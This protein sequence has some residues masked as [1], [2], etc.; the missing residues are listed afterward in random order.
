VRAIVNGRETLDSAR[1]VVSTDVDEP[2]APEITNA[3]CYDTGSIFV[4]WR[5]PQ[6]FFKSIDYYKLYYRPRVSGGDSD[7][8]RNVT[9]QASDSELQRVRPSHYSQLSSSL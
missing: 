2:S 1:I 6:R 5:R 4:V 9:I 3:T 8:F 7:V